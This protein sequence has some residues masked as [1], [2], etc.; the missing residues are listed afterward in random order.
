MPKS[1]TV[2]RLD[3]GL[4]Y[5][6]LPTT[7]SSDEVS[8]RVRVNAG[9]AQ[10]NNHFPTARIVALDTIQGTNW[11][12]STDYQQTVFDIDFA[13][14]TSSDIEKALEVLYAGLT[15][16]VKQP[17]AEQL[18]ESAQDSLTDID[19]LISQRHLDTLTQALAPLDEQSLSQTPLESVKEFK[20]TYFTP[21]QVSIVVVGGIKKKSAIKSIERQFSLW[22]TTTQEQSLHSTP[23]LEL[24]SKAEEA[25]PITISSLSTFHDEEDSKLHRKELLMT[26]LANKMLEQRIQEALSEQHLQ[27]QV[28]V[29]NQVL[30]DHRLLS[31]V[32]V[33][34]L[35]ETDKVEVK[36]VVQ[37][38]IKRAL[39]S[40]FTQTEY[41]MVVSQVRKQLERQTRLNDPDNYTRN[42]ADRVVAAIDS[43][44]VYTAPS[45]DLDLLNFHVAHL[46]EFDISK[47]FEH[48]WSTA[49][50]V[51]M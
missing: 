23:Q 46:N 7:R 39:A 4:R 29:D 21:K 34:N 27:A 16:E 45:Y 28:D 30:F 36:K 43:G 25:S 51:I 2:D 32:R 19:E 24:I 50:S 26:T 1:T 22:N 10:E 3:N 12:V 38:E 15:Q 11:H 40:G 35:E 14:A 41:E 37:S 5:V 6:V 13:S 44:S 18:L 42:Q 8:I 31:Q 49:S 17:N 20:Q 33:A 48:N 47:E 9:V